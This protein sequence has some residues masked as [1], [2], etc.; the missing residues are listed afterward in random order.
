MIGAGLAFGNSSEWMVPMRLPIIVPR[1]N[2]DATAG[3]LL[4]YV[5]EEE[6]LDVPCEG[7]Q[8]AFAEL[9]RVVLF[10]SSCRA[11]D[12]KVLGCTSLP[13]TVPR[14]GRV[15]CGDG[16]EGLLSVSENKIAAIDRWPDEALDGE[17]E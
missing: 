4:L 6:E 5:R 17:P 2:G 8:I 16:P 10:G 13:D 12:W 14:R 15:C 9:A 1:S 3:T 7:I 11:P